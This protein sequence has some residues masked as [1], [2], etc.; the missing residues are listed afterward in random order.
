MENLFTKPIPNQSIV[1]RPAR[2]LI[3]RFLDHAKGGDTR[4]LERDLKD[5][6]KLNQ[7]LAKVN[8]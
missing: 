4:N 8:R 7:A 2:K 5:I 1:L 6:E 3:P